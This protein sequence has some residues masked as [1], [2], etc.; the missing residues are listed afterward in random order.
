MTI[1]VLWL[2]L[3]PFCLHHLRAWGILCTSLIDTA[4][5]LPMCWAI[6]SLFNTIPHAFCLSRI[7]LYFYSFGA[8]WCCMQHVLGFPSWNQWSCTFCL[9]NYTISIY[10][11]AWSFISGCLRSSANKELASLCHPCSWVLGGNR[12]SWN[13]M[14]DGIWRGK[15]QSIWDLW[16]RDH[17]SIG[18]H[19]HW[20]Q[21]SG[22]EP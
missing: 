16:Q 4:V 20:N 8:G 7:L 12:T 19:R 13:R 15:G 22:I 11:L 2:C 6:V 1:A 5:S 10:F 9:P 18:R 3:S 17:A 14:E 21:W